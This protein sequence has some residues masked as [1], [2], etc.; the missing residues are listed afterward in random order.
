MSQL[1]LKQ[2]RR[3]HLLIGRYPVVLVA[4]YWEYN[5]E[6]VEHNNYINVDRFIQLATWCITSKL[7][8]KFYIQPNIIKY[9]LIRG[10]GV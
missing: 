1:S 2:M 3:S 9:K 8:L 4:E 10:F 6:P 5:M 7:I